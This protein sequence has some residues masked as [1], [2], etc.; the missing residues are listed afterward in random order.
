MPHKTVL[1]FS[2]LL[3]PTDNLANFIHFP[4][5]RGYFGVLTRIMEI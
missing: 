4:P 1:F 3:D 2:Y 5:S